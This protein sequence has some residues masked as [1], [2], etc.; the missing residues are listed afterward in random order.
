MEITR[1]EIIFWGN[2]LG[3]EEIPKMDWNAYV[4][5]PI[6]MLTRMKFVIAYAFAVA[7]AFDTGGTRE[8]DG[9]IGIIFSVRKWYMN[10]CM[11]IIFKPKMND[12]LK[13]FG[14]VLG[15]LRE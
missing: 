14:T 7:R 9:I 6:H 8:S 5:I 12:A 13:G 3:E 2:A 10:S 11:G 1:C 4:R 15:S